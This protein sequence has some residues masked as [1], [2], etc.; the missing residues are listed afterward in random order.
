MSEPERHARIDRSGLALRP[1]KER[2][3]KVS[4]ERDRVLPSDAPGPMSD[5]ALKLVDE[6]AVR[7]KRARAAGKSRML[8]FGAHTIKNGLAPV[9]IA[10]IE[11]GW[12]THLATNGA[13]IIHD[14]EFAYQGA[15]SEDV[16]YGVAHGTFGL[17]EE[18][19][20]YLNLA[21]AVGAYSGKGYGEAVG[22][23]VEREGIQIPSAATLREEIVDGINGNPGHAAA[24]ADLLHTISE[25]G[26]ED[27]WLPIEHPYK[28]YGLQAAAYRLGIPF[29]GHPMI[30]HDIIYVHPLNSCAAL[31]RCA[32]RDFLAFAHGVTRLDGGAYI[33]VGSSV[34][35]PMIFEK[36]MSMAQN[37]AIQEGRRIEGHFIAV[38]DLAESQWDWKKGEPPVDDPAY[39]LR[40]NKTFS[41]MGG[42]MRYAQADNR[43]FLLALG[44][45][46][47]TT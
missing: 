26:I 38:V 47:Y 11:E 9:I 40:Y 46:L 31:G 34:M 14:W 13:G 42:A 12:F 33:S 27:G 45:A 28:R 1:L 44:Q 6:T 35:S 23:M 21:L 7:L 16:R 29:T 17:W 30:G 20:R 3:N 39:Y 43:D 32:E 41:R 2:P 15:S 22:E 4:I 24:A 5:V 25:H 10:L 36:S 37:L 19:G 8:A 18:T